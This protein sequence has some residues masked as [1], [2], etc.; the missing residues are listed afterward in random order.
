MFLFPTPPPPPPPPAADQTREAMIAILSIA[1]GALLVLVL[2][3]PKPATPSTEPMAEAQK[4]S[5]RAAS[6][7][8]PAELQLLLEYRR[9][10]VPEGY[11]GA[12]IP[13]QHV[14][15]I[16]EAAPWAPNHGKTEPWRFVV[17]GGAAKQTLIDATLA[18]YSAQPAGFW[19][20]AFVS[21]KTGVAEFADGA[22]FAAY[23]LDAGVARW[24]RASHLIAICV[25]RQRPVA[26]KKQYP[27]WEEDMAVACSVQNMHLKATTLK[28]GAYWSSWYPEYRASRELVSFLGL[29]PEQGDRCL[30]IFILGD[31]AAEKMVSSRATRLPTEEIATTR[32]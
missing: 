3:R 19:K 6:N 7:V 12:P 16:L 2:S 32:E 21:A 18:W 15:A 25:R 14:R 5:V 22:A 11:T 27:P 29:D 8:S 24:K 9:S 30:G 13:A 17:F 1:V 28:V 23:F 4:S 20:S 26:G 31:V 10:V